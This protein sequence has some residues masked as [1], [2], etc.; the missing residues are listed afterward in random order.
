[1]SGAVADPLGP[2]D[3]FAEQV[4][5]PMAD[6]IRLATDVYLPRGGRGADRLPCILVRLPYDKSAPFAFMPRLAAWF[7]ERGYAFVAQDVRGR[8]RSE[9]E[10]FAFVHEVSD[11][12]A[13]LDWIVDQPWSNGVVGMFGDS[14]YGWTQWAAVASGHEALEGDRPPGDIGGGRDGLARDRRGVQRLPDDRVGRGNLVGDGE[15]RV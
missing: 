15:L 10:T 7:T 1:M 13:T 4:M 8:A 2:I 6:G 9:G 11:G 3:E 12:S 5:V 14:Y